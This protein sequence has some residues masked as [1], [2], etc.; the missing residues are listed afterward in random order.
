MIEGLNGT[1]RDLVGDGQR[2]GILR[3]DMDRRG[4]LGAVTFRDMFLRVKGDTG[5]FGAASFFK[6]ASQRHVVS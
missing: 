2:T 6:Q 4:I 3:D 1:V 5:V